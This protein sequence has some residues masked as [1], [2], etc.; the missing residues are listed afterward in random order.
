MGEGGFAELD[1]VRG[2]D[3]EGLCGCIVQVNAERGTGE[4]PGLR[5]GRDL[6]RSGGRF[7]EV[8]GHEDSFL[9]ERVFSGDDNFVQGNAF[10]IR[11]TGYI[12]GVR[13][14]VQEGLEGY[15][16]GP[17]AVDVRGF[18]LLSWHRAPKS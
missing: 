8:V 2:A 10:Y 1:F 9:V 5:Y 6:L 11:E 4:L 15:G 3:D 17:G 12:E 18:G 14:I 7:E 16:K 13:A